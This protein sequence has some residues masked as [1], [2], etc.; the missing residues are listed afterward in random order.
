MGKSSTLVAVARKASTLGGVVMMDP[1]G[2]T[3]RS[4]LLGLSEPERSRLV[5]V[6]PHAGSSGINALEGIG[7]RETDPVL[8]DRRLNDLVHALRRVRSGRYIDSFW[9]PRLEEMLTRAIRAASAFPLGTLADAHTLLATGGKTR[10]VV[11]PEAQEAVRELS[12]RIRERPEDAEGARRLLYEVVRSPVLVRMLCERNP[13]L[14]A[15]ELVEPGRIAVISGEASSV[16]ESVARYLLA[17]YL[18]L[19][20]S[21]L[22][23]RPTRAKTFVILD[24]SQW[25]SHESLAEMLRLARRGNVHIVLATQTVGSLSETVADALW[26]N[27]SDFVAFR[28]SPEEARELS[29]ATRG[30]TVEEILSLPRGH[31]AVL[32]GKGSS[33]E[34]VRTVGRP[35]VSASAPSTEEAVPFDPGGEAVIPGPR[36]TRPRVTAEQ[37][38][39]WLREKAS[40]LPAGETLRVDLTELR[41]TLDPDERALREAGSRL[42]RAGALRASTRSANGSVWLLDPTKIPRAAA[43]PPPSPSAEAS[44]APQPS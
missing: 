22:L 3:A 23:A 44:P 32:L 21:E 8:S 2:E 38:L 27:V 40:G 28:G 41:E 24:E 7:G 37:V 25:F 6:A 11:P 15:R 42:G 36:E 9:G 20:W 10:Q 26:T 4:F 19:V 35:P 33:L 30:L 5:W 39:E 29:R 13:T 31:A 17:V 12:E 18:A 1:L 34:W 43:A 14:H 16:G